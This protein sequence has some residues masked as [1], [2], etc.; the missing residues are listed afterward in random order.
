VRFWDANAVVP[1]LVDEDRSSTVGGFLRGDPGMVVWWITR[2]ECVSALA[3]KRRDG[4]IGPLEQAQAR[5]VLHHLGGAWTEVLPSDVLRARAELLL[6]RHPLRTADAYQLA[7]ALDWRNGS[8][9][10]AG[11]V[12]FD[13]RLRAAAGA[14]GFG[15]LPTNL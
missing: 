10:G 4:T 11:F 14:E 12:C 15:V 6:D 7:A 2:S 9:A 3:R 1:L 5:V 8:P 13:R